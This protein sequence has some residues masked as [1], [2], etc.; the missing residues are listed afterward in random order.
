V[1]DTVGGETLEQS[2]PIVKRG[3]IIVSSAEPP[4]TQKAEHYG[5]SATFFLVEVTRERLGQ[6]AGLI[7][8]GELKTE[9]GEVLWLDEARRAHEMLEGAPHRRGKIVIKIAD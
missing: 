2:Y 9:V 8:G 1:L 5:V 6:I 3:G 4:S 7:D